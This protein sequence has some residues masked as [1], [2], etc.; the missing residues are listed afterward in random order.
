MV[1]RPRRSGTY[2]RAARSHSRPKKQRGAPQRPH[3]LLF[4]LLD[5]KLI[6]VLRD[7]GR[8]RWGRRILTLEE[9]AKR[10]GKTEASLRAEWLAWWMPV[11][12][13]AQLGEIDP[14]LVPPKGAVPAPRGMKW[15]WQDTGK[16]LD[17][18]ARRDDETD[19]V[20]SYQV[21]VLVP[22]TVPPHWRAEM[23]IA[24]VRVSRRKDRRAAYE[25][26]RRIARRP[27]LLDDLKKDRDVVDGR[28]NARPGFAEIYFVPKP[29]VPLD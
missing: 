29:V 1:T 4:E 21:M 15:W 11:L 13:D 7:V 25:L 2:K 14:A 16:R 23:P 26:A 20:I 27:A 24:A 18:Q 17:V 3:W 9:A 8:R 12:S 5:D 19:E 6:P 10:P 28:S 22:K